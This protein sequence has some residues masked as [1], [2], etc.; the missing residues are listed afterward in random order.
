MF[1]LKRCCCNAVMN[2]DEETIK[3]VAFKF[4]ADKDLMQALIRKL[5]ET[6]V[7]MLQQ[8]ASQKF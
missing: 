6:S 8:R 7:L 1:I 4:I 3:K 2:A 5:K